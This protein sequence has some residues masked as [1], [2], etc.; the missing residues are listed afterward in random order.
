MVGCFIQGVTQFHTLPCYLRIIDIV[1]YV[2][3]YCIYH[4]IM[5][6]CI[7]LYSDSN[8]S[9]NCIVL[10]YIK[11]SRHQRLHTGFAATFSCKKGRFPHGFPVLPTQDSANRAGFYTYFKGKITNHWFILLH[12]FFGRQKCPGQATNKDNVQDAVSS[13]FSLC[14]TFAC[15]DVGFVGPF[16]LLQVY[17]CHEYLGIPN[18]SWFQIRWKST[19][20]FVGNIAHPWKLT[21][22]PTNPHSCRSPG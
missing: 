5:L 17:T 7:I 13:V 6:Y 20:G 2:I 18:V 19:N 14:V 21:W 11:R 16:E 1:Y 15:D 12:F 8:C 4:I 3:L 9:C 22:D 10:Y